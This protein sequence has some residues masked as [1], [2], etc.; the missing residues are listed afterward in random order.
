LKFPFNKLV[1]GLKKVNF[2]RYCSNFNPQT[3]LLKG[4]F[5]LWLHLSLTMSRKDV[6]GTASEPPSL[7]LSNAHLFTGVGRTAHI[8]FD[9]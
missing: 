8:I 9:I 4:N 3:S 5:K 7:G 6:L 1:W 2:S